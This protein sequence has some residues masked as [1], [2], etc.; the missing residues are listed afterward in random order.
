MK[1]RKS[2]E[3]ED[4]D[5]VP[6][7]FCHFPFLLDATAKRR[8]LEMESK[9]RMSETVHRSRLEHM[10]G[11]AT[12]LHQ[13]FG[14]PVPHGGSRPKTGRRWGGASTCLG[15]AAAEATTAH[16]DRASG[17]RTDPRWTRRS[18][19]RNA[20]RLARDPPA[21]RRAPLRM[22]RASYRARNRCNSLHRT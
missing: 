19:V 6:F 5:R 1:W 22:A 13:L 7:T 11:D 17:F 4:E 8:I 14:M 3:L 16:R 21:Q 12:F 20:G 10:F 9:V 15:T 18:F 2:E